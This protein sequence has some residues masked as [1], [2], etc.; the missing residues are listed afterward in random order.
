MIGGRSTPSAT[1]SATR[2]ATR[3]ATHSATPIATPRPCDTN[4]QCKVYNIH[5]MYIHVYVRNHK[6]WYVCM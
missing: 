5:I 4:E 3:S 6:L 1:P 2:S